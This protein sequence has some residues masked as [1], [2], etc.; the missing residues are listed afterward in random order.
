MLRGYVPNIYINKIPPAIR[1]SDNA[2]KHCPLTSTQILAYSLL[3]T[4]SSPVNVP[5]P[6]E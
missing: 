5:A 1:L 4:A 2:I 3:D 6:R